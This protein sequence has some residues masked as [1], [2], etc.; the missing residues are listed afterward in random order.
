M[1]PM[2]GCPIVAAPRLQGRGHAPPRG[3]C[4][5]LASAA[6]QN[7]L[8]DVWVLTL[9]PGQGA[10]LEKGDYLPARGTFLF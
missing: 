7:I 8:I 1:L 3:L 5:A 2:Q 6:C 9:H 10:W 4:A